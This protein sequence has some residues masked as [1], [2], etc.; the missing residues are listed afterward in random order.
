MYAST[1]LLYS[2]MAY[3]FI[4]GALSMST[5][6]RRHCLLEAYVRRMLIRR[7]PHSVGNSA[8]ETSAATISGLRYLAQYLSRSGQSVF[9][10]ETIQPDWLSDRDR[11]YRY[12]LMLGLVLA[13]L[14]SIVPTV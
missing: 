7:Q 12:P 14:M 5:K 4:A 2:S 13:S 1:Q 10:I 11:Q 8:S 9:Q 3:S 6:A